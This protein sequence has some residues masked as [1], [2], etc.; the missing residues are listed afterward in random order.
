MRPRPPRGAGAIGAAHYRA[1]FGE[2]PPDKKIGPQSPQ[3]DAGRNSKHDP[4]IV[5]RNVERGK[6][7]MPPCPDR[8]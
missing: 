2:Q 7:P 8:R 4:G 6:G 1:L 5:A 3:S